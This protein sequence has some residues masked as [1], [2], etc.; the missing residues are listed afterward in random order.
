MCVADNCLFTCLSV[1]CDVH[2]GLCYSL[3]RVQSAPQ[4]VLCSKLRDPSHA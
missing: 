3:T 2:G 1:D 4:Q